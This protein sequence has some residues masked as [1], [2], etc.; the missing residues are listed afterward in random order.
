MLAASLTAILYKFD[1]LTSESHVVGAMSP[2]QKSTY[3][4]SSLVLSFILIASIVG[5]LLFAAT[6]L[7]A[8][9][10]LDARRS[11]LLRRLRYAKDKK[12]VVLQPLADPQAFH[13]LNDITYS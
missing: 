12:D 4:T 2:Y 8:Q 5:S 13:R 11:R 6:V 7:A 10:A 1:A 9:V 3:I